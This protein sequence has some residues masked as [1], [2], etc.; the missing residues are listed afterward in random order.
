[1]T[2]VSK[3]KT[4]EF[5]KD[6]ATE[7]ALALFVFAVTV[8]L[9]DHRR[10]R[11]EQ[12]EADL[13]VARDW[14]TVHEIFVPDHAHGENPLIVYDRTIYEPFVGFWVAEVQHRD[15]GDVPSTF[16]N[17]CTGSGTATYSLED[18]LPE[19]GVSWEWFLDRPCEV[20]PGQYRIVVTY[21]LHIE[22]YPIKR[23]EAR[24]NVFTVY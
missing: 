20:G 21:D 6:R 2:L 3:M 1:M 14:F 4:W 17:T 18:S 24:S 7:M 23:Q 12:Q 15:G 11:I 13:F 5:W 22:G 10:D 19:D 16:F 9:L 8:N